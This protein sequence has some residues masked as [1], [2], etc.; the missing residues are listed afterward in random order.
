MFQMPQ[1]S[2]L[3]QHNRIRWAVADT[4]IW[5]GFASVIIP[6]LTINRVCWA[7]NYLL[8]NRTKLPGPTQKWVSTAVG[9]ACIPFIIKPIDKSVDFIMEYTFRKKYRKTPD[10]EVIITH[11][12]NH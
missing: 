9:L 3:V 4:F 8:R 12:R 11:S 7:S 5:Q 2:D 10:L 1:E 6:G